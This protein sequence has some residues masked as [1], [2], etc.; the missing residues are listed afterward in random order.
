MRCNILW[1]GI[2]D[3]M[4]MERVRMSEAFLAKI[5]RCSKAML[6]SIVMMDESAMWFHT[7]ATKQPSKHRLEKEEG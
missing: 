7:P 4:T 5:P 1:I 6:G 2:L 3:E